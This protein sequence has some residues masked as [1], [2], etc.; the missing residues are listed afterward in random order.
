[1][2]LKKKKITYI[3]FLQ[4][5]LFLQISSYCQWNTSR[6]V[7]KSFLGH[8][9]WEAQ[10]RESRLLQLIL[11]NTFEEVGGAYLF[12]R[13]SSFSSIHPKRLTTWDR[14]TLH[15]VLSLLSSASVFSL[16][17]IILSRNNPWESCV[18]SFFCWHLTPLRQM[19]QVQ[20]LFLYL[21]CDQKLFSASCQNGKELANW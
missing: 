2:T 20:N 6:W 10:L 21:S 13:A 16:S 3:H 5:N 15:S 8:W 14:E 11:G 19:P 12:L 9:N 18:I 4:S 17:L 7:S 1:M